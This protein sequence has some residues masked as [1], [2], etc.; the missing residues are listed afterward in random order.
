MSRAADPSEF[1]CPNCLHEALVAT[2]A[3]VSCPACGK[4]YEIDDGIP[5]FGERLAAFDWGVPVEEIERTLEEVERFGWHDAVMRLYE[6]LTPG[7]AE[8]FWLRA[9]GLRRLALQMLLPVGPKAEVL[10]CG[11]GWGTVALH[12]AAFCGR[13]VAFDQVGLHL[14]WLRAACRARGVENVVLVQ[15]GDTRHLPF[16][17]ESFDAVILNGVLEHV[18]VNI[19]GEPRAIQQLF[20]DEVARILKP[21]GSLYIGIENRLNYKYFLGVREGHIQMKYG[22]LLPRFLT[23]W[24]L[25]WRRGRPYREYTYSL[26]G[27][28]ELLDCAGFSHRKFFAPWPTYSSAGEF[29]P[30]Q[31]TRRSALWRVES[32]H[33]AARWPGWY[34]AR[35]YAM[36]ASKKA[37]EPSLLERLV[38]EISLRAG[39]D[40]PWILKGAV[41]TA[42]SGGKAI[43]R[44]AGPDGRDWYAQ[45]GLTPLAGAWI[46]A[47]YRSISAIHARPLPPEVKQRIPVPVMAG[48]IEG[49]TY[50]IREYRAGVNGGSLIGRAGGREALCRDAEAFL[51]GLHGTGRCV[52]EIDEA[53][54]HRLFGE[55]IAAAEQWFTAEE[56][57]RSGAW[58]EQRAAWIRSLT[59]GGRLPVVPY[60]GDFTPENCVCDASSGR[61]VQVLD[62]ELYQEDGLPMVD[63]VTFLGCAYRPR[64]KAE[65]WARGEDP[66]L[67]KFH[68]YPF[69]FLEEPLREALHRYLERMG[70]GRELLLP[71]LFM[72]WIRQL[73]D[74][75]PLLLY[76][77]DWRRLRVFPVMERWDRL[78]GSGIGR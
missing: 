61:L 8:L 58:F 22:A 52:V 15:G 55:P 76:H 13:V 78:L 11:S 37:P 19:P 6:R 34:F 29:F 12:L 62:W 5:V 75:A 24:Y 28:R 39:Q 60:H 14:R 64:V 54:F 23:R 33:P 51:V 77:P 45:L 41:F 63:W 72:W 43:V 74:W 20:L 30:V 46:S 66:G 21:S 7:P 57:G 10:D 40:S 56:W 35:A 25:R 53:R 32:R 59:L 31:D 36:A 50:A 3:A 9:L 4:R 42:T 47:Q 73:K 26:R 17:S 71:L 70:I 2:E 1:V 16:P 48:E 69:I 65:M 44:L 68:G 38:R 67:V 18:A 49:Y 27:Y